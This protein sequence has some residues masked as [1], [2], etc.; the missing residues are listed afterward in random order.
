MDKPQQDSPTLSKDPL[1]RSW[2]SGEDVS[3]PCDGCGRSLPLLVFQDTAARCL[4]VLCKTCYANP[5]ATLQRSPGSRV[6]A[7]SRR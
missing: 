6:F 4:V 1:F 3:G 5:P 2:K 7:A